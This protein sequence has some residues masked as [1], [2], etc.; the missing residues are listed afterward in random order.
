[1]RTATAASILPNERR[2]RLLGPQRVED[3]TDDC[4]A[5]FVLPESLDEPPAFVQG[6]GLHRIPFSVAFEFG[7]PVLAIGLRDGSVD[8]TRVPEA[9]VDEYRQLPTR[10]YYVRTHPSG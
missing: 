9:S 4:R 3:T 1:M 6:R 8:G 5:V 7:L 10:E 2:A